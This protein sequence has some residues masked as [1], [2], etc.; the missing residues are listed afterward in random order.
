MKRILY[1]LSLVFMLTVASFT[2]TMARESVDRD[3]PALADCPSGT[4]HRKDALYEIKG[5]ANSHEAVL[6]NS[7]DYFRTTNTRP[8]RP[9]PTFQAPAGTPLLRT[10]TDRRI[11]WSDYCRSLHVRCTLPIRPLASVDYHVYLLRHIIR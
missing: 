2:E 9:L 11:H 6:E 7:Q 3:T 4:T 1:L 10:F 5:S 8:G